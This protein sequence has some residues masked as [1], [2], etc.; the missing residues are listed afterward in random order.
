MKQ[1]FMVV[2]E[3]ANGTYSGYAPDLP[4]SIATGETH[5]EIRTNLREAVDNHVRLLVAQG[6]EVPSPV[7]H[8]VKCPKP[9]Q[10]SDVQH[11]IVERLKIEVP[12]SSMAAQKLAS[13]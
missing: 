2:Y 6:N 11:W 7:A 1:R 9:V 8:I 5:E 10:E 3:F 13:A 12:V 4:G